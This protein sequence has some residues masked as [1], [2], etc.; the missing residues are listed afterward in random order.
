ML[1]MTSYAISL[2]SQSLD[3]EVR[4]PALESSGSVL[5]AAHDV[6]SIEESYF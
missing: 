2:R 4:S 3:M 6:I 5:D 1:V